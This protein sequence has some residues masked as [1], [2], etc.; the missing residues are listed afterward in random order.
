MAPSGS[1][2]AQRRSSAQAAWSQWEQPAC[3]QMRGCMWVSMRRQ[4]WARHAQFQQPRTYPRARSG[5]RRPG[6]APAGTERTRARPRPQHRRR[7]R[8]AWRPRRAAGVAGRGASTSG[9]C[10]CSYCYRHMACSVVQC[11]AM[12]S[13]RGPRGH[14]SYRQPSPGIHPPDAPVRVVLRQQRPV[15]VLHPQPR[16]PVV[17]ATILLLPGSSALAFCGCGCSSCSYPSPSG[18]ECPAVFPL[19]LLRRGGRHR[20][21]LCVGGD[22]WVGFG[23]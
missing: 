2:S 17:V 14:P 11:D 8:D 22:W 21:L 19:R 13:V 18:L 10:C 7:R 16:G 9:T 15:P 12:E 1:W 3:S 20:G 5:S 23:E 4:G 6:S